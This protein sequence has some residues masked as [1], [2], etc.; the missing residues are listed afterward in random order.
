MMEYTQDC[1]KSSIDTQSSRNKNVSCE[2]ILEM[3]NRHKLE[4]DLSYK[5]N[6]KK[7]KNS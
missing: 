3:T 1:Q 5:N 2:K 7:K 4:N 6:A